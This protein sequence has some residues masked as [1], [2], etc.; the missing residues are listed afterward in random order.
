MATAMKPK[1]RLNILNKSHPAFEISDKHRRFLGLWIPVTKWL[2][3]TTGEFKYLVREQERLQEAH[4]VAEIVI[5]NDRYCLFRTVNETDLV[6]GR[7]LYD[8]L[9]HI[10]FHGVIAL[11]TAKCKRGEG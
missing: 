4:F 7:E 6:G 2:E 8:W 5:S 9:K 11:A 1:E 10:E 3:A